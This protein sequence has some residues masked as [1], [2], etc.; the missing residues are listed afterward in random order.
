[1]AMACESMGMCRCRQS[2]RSWS[3]TISTVFITRMAPSSVFGHHGL[4]RAFSRYPAHVVCRSDR[5]A[6]ATGRPPDKAGVSSANPSKARS[7]TRA[8]R[9]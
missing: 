9:S 8:F 1:M 4:K 5:A 6:S 7:S 2:A 3:E